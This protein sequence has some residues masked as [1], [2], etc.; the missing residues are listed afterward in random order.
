MATLSVIIPSKGRES[1]RETLASIPDW[2]EVIV[3]ADEGHDGYQNA[4]QIASPRAKMLATG[5]S[6]LGHP[7]RQLGMAEATG[8]WLCFIDDDDVYTE[9]AFLAFK[10]AMTRKRPTLFRMR[11]EDEDTIL[12]NEPRVAH[13]NVGTPMILTPNVPAKLGEWAWKR[14]GDFDFIRDTVANFGGCTFDETIV[15]T[16]RRL[17]HSPYYVTVS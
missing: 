17:D 3:V 4:Y 15:C 2:P 11:Y 9:E 1:L 10:K 12:W 5:P 16:V 6:I 13:C 8:G 7:Q 14:T